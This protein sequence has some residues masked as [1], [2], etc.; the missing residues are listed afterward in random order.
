MFEEVIRRVRVLNDLLKEQKNT[1]LRTI[2]RMLGMSVLRKMFYEKEEYQTIG[3][4]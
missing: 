3:P 2:N 1:H 4:C